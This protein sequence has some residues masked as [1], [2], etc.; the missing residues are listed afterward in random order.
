MSKIELHLGLPNFGGLLHAPFVRS[1]LACQQNGK[2]RFANMTFID[3]DSLVNR[4]RN[5]CVEAF[6]RGAHTH[7]VFIDTDIEFT[8][9]DV[10]KLAEHLKEHTIVSGLYP[11]KQDKLEWVINTLEHVDLDSL[12]DPLIEIKY[13]GTGFLAIAREVFTDIAAGPAR[14]LWYWTDNG[15]GDRRQQIDYFPVGVKKYPDGNRRFLSEDWFFCDMAR[16]A[17]HKIMCDTSIRTKHIGK[18]TYG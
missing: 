18:K 16:E 10:D 15:M 5:N 9:E 2:P 11:K 4:A 7:L 12:E 13:A 14:D 1:L 6:L 8:P 3:G 17:G